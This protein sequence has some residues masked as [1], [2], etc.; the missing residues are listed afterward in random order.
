MNNTIFPI[1]IRYMLVLFSLKRTYRHRRASVP[2]DYVVIVGQVFYYN[3]V[4]AEHL[5]VLNKSGTLV[6]KL[7]PTFILD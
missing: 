3:L 7:G 1:I 5:P 6:I 4:I 2:G